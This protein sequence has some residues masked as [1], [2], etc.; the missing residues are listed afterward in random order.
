MSKSRNRNDDPFAVLFNNS[1]NNNNNNN[2]NFVKNL[3]ES[4]TIGASPLYPSFY[5]AVINGDRDRGDD[6]LV[7]EDFANTIK[8]KQTFPNGLT[9]EVL[10]IIGRYG[11]FQKAY[12]ITKAYGLIGSAE[13]GAANA[14]EFKL[15]VSKNGEQKGGSFVVYTNGKVRFSGGYVGIDEDRSMKEQLERQPDLVRSHIVD[16]YFEGLRILKNPIEFNN[17]G[18]EFRV[19]TRFNPDRVTQD[20]TAGAT[21]IDYDPELSA[22][23]KIK[24]PE[25][26]TLSVAVSGVI[27]IL[28]CK[29]PAELMKAYKKGLEVVEL[30][31]DTRAV[32]GPLNR[33]K[34]SPRPTR[35]S[36]MQTNKPAPG[37]TRRGTTCPKDSRP[38][39]YSFQGRCPKPGSY[40]RPNPQGQPCCYKIPKSIRYSRNKVAKL[41]KDANVKVPEDVQKIFGIKN[42]ATNTKNNNVSNSNPRIITRNDPRSG[43]MIDSRQC[44]RYTREKLYDIA[45][46]LKIEEANP[47]TTKTMLCLLIR[48]DGKRR[49]F[50][51]TETMSKKGKLAVKVKMAGKD[52][53]VS[54]KNNDLRLGRRMCKT[55]K[56]KPLLV[57]AAKMGARV[58]ADMKVPEICQAIEAARNAQYKKMKEGV[59]KEATKREVAKKAA[60]NARAARAAKIAQEEAERAEAEARK[61]VE[62]GLLKVRL[63]N[64]EVRAD[65]EKL[66]GKRWLGKYNVSLNNDVSEFV[67]MISANN[68]NILQYGSKGLPLKGSVDRAKEAFIKRRKDQQRSAYFNTLNDLNRLGGKGLSVNSYRRAVRNFA[69]QE[70]KPTDAAIEKF[71]K[72]WIKLRR[73]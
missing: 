24:Y 34:V 58:T 46:R 66:Y 12:E 40:V 19:N 18:G 25:N 36:K 73:S 65:F 67:N 4:L 15:K 1:N 56:K 59:N 33:E 69:L 5:N 30:M 49:G 52:F 16:K 11:R 14:L 2:N 61:R 7:M 31:K 29:N 32:R 51:K 62:A 42:A 8:P 23:L 22:M 37:V 68:S 21:S 26:Y 28:G 9:V 57:F 55:Y 39:P 71:K 60:A 70:P 3:E 13:L 17:I 20:M 10:S 6:V 64:K 35:V 27:Q 43:F 41:Y 38:V 72:T 48:R 45:K 47:S 50:N 44:M 63:G 53:V 54:G